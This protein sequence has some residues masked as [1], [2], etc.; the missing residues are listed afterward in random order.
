[1]SILEVLIAFAVLMGGLL[2]FARALVCS[3]EASNTSHEATLARE[4][5]RRM[6]ENLRSEAFADLFVRHNGDPQDDPGAPGSAPGKDFVVDGLSPWDRDPDGFAGEILFPV[7]AATPAF[8]RE[9]VVLPRL[10]MPRDLTG[11]GVIDAQDHA[12]DY[13][14]LPVLV[15]VDWRSASGRGRVELR[16]MLGDLQ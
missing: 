15:R 3:M 6:I 9:D 1:M 4:A 8:L 7:N 5:A 11:D 13:L 12:G 2:G 10:G 16:T 14:L